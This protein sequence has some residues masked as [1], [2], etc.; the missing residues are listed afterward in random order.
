MPRIVTARHEAA[1]LANAA[2]GPHTAGSA[3]GK[4]SGG[5]A[6]SSS[7]LPGIRATTVRS[8]LHST[9]TGKRNSL[10]FT[11]MSR[12]SSRPPTA[13]SG[14]PGRGGAEKPLYQPALGRPARQ[15]VP[16]RELEL[17][18]DGGDVRLD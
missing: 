7:G 1:A 8:W 5:V 16:V 10:I 6:I 17:A 12:V 11:V 9:S 15:L 3:S 18:E 2:S 14:R 4:N 13:A